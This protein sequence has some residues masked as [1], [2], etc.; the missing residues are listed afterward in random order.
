MTLDQIKTYYSLTKPGV[1]FGNAITAA[2]GFFLASRGHIDWWLGLALFVGTS[3]VIA[4][5]CVINNVLDQDIDSLMARTKTRALVAG[6]ANATIATWLSVALGVGGLAILI[7]FTNWLV[8][9]VGLVG[10]VDY[11]VLY[12][13]L[14]KRLSIHGTLVGSISGAT[15]V[16]AGYVAVTGRIDLGAIIVFAILFLWQM[17]EFYS[18]AIYRRDE[19]RAAGV[20]VMTVVKGIHSTKIQIVAYAAAFFVAVVS[21]ALFGYAGYSY[22]I[23]MGI[24]SA[25]WLWL[26]VRGLGASDDNA[27]SRMMFRFSLVIILALSLMM[28]VGSVLP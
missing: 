4:S 7:A 12:G 16:L 28:A 11:V 24:L 15:P 14:S 20:P 18:I 23:V 17:P 8:V 5:A 1:L 26:G 27:W 9:V 22:L 10:F 2:A 25:Y 3:L 6:R 21:L 13:M 19:Y